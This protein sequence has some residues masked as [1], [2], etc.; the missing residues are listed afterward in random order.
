MRQRERIPGLR[1]AN[2]NSSF[3]RCGSSICW[4][5][6]NT[7]FFFIS[8]LQTE[9]RQLLESVLK[10]RKARVHYREREG[11]HPRCYRYR[12]RR[13]QLQAGGPGRQSLWA[14]SAQLQ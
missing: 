1:H 11:S 3:C 8:Q 4:T 9:T 2:L 7:Q 6:Y 14:M 12:Q 13:R 10:F 5:C